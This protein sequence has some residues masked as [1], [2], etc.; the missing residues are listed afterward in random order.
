MGNAKLSDDYLLLYLLTI[1][2]AIKTK[3]LQSLTIDV[4]EGRHTQN[5]PSR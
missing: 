5:F 3:L 1:F 2:V 4:G